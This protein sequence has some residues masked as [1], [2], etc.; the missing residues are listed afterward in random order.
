MGSIVGSITGVNPVV[1]GTLTVTGPVNA[2]RY[3]ASSVGAV[4]SG[5]E[6]FEIAGRG[7]LYSGAAGEVAVAAGGALAATGTSGAWTTNGL[8]AA[9]RVF[10]A[11]LSG[12]VQAGVAITG[13][14][15]TF[16]FAG[17]IQPFSSNGVYTLTSTPF[18]SGGAAGELIIL[19]NTGANAVTLQDNSIVASGLHLT[20]VSRVLA[21]GDGIFMRCTAPGVWWEVS[22]ANVT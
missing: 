14:G 13:V 12:A 8:A 19:Y 3:V 4:T 20:G 22:F 10:A 18:I 16:A 5:Q 21:L 2:T 7:G 15:S 1:Q 17:T 9:T 6:S 11:S